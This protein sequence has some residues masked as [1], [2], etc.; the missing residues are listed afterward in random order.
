MR[1]FLCGVTLVA[2]G[3]IAGCGEPDPADNPHFHSETAADPGAVIKQLSP[4][5]TSTPKPMSADPSAAAETV[6]AG[7]PAGGAAPATKP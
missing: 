6:P 5:G 2:V 1:A 4:D 7:T 3:L